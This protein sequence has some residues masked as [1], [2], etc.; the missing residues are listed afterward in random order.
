[1]RTVFKALRRLWD[2]LFRGSNGYTF[3]KVEDLPDSLRT[4]VVYIAGENGHLWYAAFVCPCGCNA[5]IQLG[6]M[7]GQRPRWH[8]T[9]HDDGTI[10]L[11]PSVWRKVG[12]RS[13]FHLKKGMVK[14]AGTQ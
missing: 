2:R 4:D 3:A 14:W 6:L 5:T 8:I 10:S 11:H 9:E 1:M 13:H 7:E 12:C